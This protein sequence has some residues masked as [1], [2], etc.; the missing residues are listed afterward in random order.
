[1]GGLDCTV[2]DHQVG[3]SGPDVGVILC[4]GYGAPGTD[5]VPLASVIA[6]ALTA[7]VRVRFLFPKPPILMDGFMGPHGQWGHMDSNGFQWNPMGFV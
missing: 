6:A 7:D 4:H 5:L 2:I 3:A 1:M